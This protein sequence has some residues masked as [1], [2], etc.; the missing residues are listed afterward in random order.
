MSSRKPP[1]WRNLRLG[2]FFLI[3][4]AVLVYSLLV[5]GTN[6]QIFSRYYE[7]TM[8]MT[9]AQGLAAGGMVS[10]S[11]LEIGK[12]SEIVF[13]EENEL[14]ITI[15]VQEAHR[16]RITTSSEA[17]IRTVGVLGD[18]FVDISLGNPGEAPLP[19]GAELPVR[20]SVD[21]AAT[22][23]RASLI[24]DDLL[25]LTEEARNTMLRVNRG[26]GTIGMLFNDPR[27]AEDLR[28]TTSNLADATGTLGAGSGGSMSRLLHDET[29]VSRLDSLLVRM[30]GLVAKVDSGNGAIPRLM[31]D[32]DLGERVV[33][34]IAGSDSLITA[35]RT[36][37]TTGRLVNDE[38]LY[39]DLD[40]A[41]GELQSLMQDMRE[42]PRKYFKVSVF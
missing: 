35:I 30:E 23:E 31:T 39:D 1:G 22:L 18:K 20:G 11:G 36:H 27:M 41:L 5:V 29:T 38:T 40:A 34:L 17:T 16:A 9:N 32:E 24:V 12:I 25:E 4:L 14:E 10:L 19:D 8:R 13:T 26:E 33:N 42:N 21:W 15:K 3:A 2:I 28:R 37:G 7:L 6:Q